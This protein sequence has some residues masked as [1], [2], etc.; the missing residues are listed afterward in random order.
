[1][2]FKTRL[3]ILNSLLLLALGGAAWGRRADD[4][5][6]TRKDFLRPLGLPYRVCTTK[7]IELGEDEQEM[8]EPDAALVRQYS[9]GGKIQ[10]ELAVIAGHQKRTVHTPGF[11]LAGGGWEVVSKQKVR[12]DLGT[13]VV[14]AQQDMLVKDQ[15]GML[16]TY[17]FTDGSFCTESLPRYQWLQLG[18]RLRGSFPLGAL[19]R[20]RVPVTRDPAAMTSNTEQ[21]AQAVVPPVL[22][23]LREA[24][25]SAR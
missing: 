16:V 5:T 14:P 24:G 8:L 10:A 21:F 4:L 18:K 9:L 6:L 19:V 7:D 3:W 15:V 11:C 23:A 20:I 22:R 1:M 13:Q 25:A 2:L 12:L 17:F